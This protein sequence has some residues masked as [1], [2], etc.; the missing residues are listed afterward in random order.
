MAQEPAATIRSIK[1]AFLP[2]VLKPFPFRISLS[3]STLL[4]LSSPAF[5]RFGG[6]RVRT[7]HDRAPPSKTR[8]TRAA[9]SE[10]LAGECLIARQSCCSGCS[11]KARP[12]SMI[13]SGTRARA[14]TR[15]CVFE[16]LWTLL[17]LA[18]RPRRRISS[19][20]SAARHGLCRRPAVSKTMGRAH[21]DEVQR[22]HRLPPQP[23]KFRDPQREHLLSSRYI[24]FESNQDSR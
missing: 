11:K 17:T 21:P 5:S 6:E 24:I 3:S 4:P 13:P 8:R 20:G 16:Y 18:H 10:S 12:C 2:L 14:A 7:G 22:I 23:P 1:S 9:S 15:L 19:Q